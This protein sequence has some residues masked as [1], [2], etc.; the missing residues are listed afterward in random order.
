MMAKSVKSSD[1]SLDAT[2]NANQD[3]KQVTAVDVSD[4]RIAERAYQLWEQGGRQEGTAEL[5][6]NRAE[7]E[8][9]GESA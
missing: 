2:E 9:S 8:L 5:D 7:D 3:G 1:A 6:W 4:E